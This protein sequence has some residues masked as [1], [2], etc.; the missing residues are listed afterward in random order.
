M[1]KER[2]PSVH[3]LLGGSGPFR[4]REGVRRLLGMGSRGGRTARPGSFVPPVGFRYLKNQPSVGLGVSSPPASRPSVVEF[5][6]LGSGRAESGG[7]HRARPEMRPSGRLPVE[8]VET[9]QTAS[10]TSAATPRKRAVA[11][12]AAQQGP[13]PE[14]R[15]EA[16]SGLRNVPAASPPPSDRAVRAEA[17]PP[18]AESPV[19]TTSRAAEPPLSQAVEA[20]KTGR[21]PLKH[22]SAESG[23]TLNHRPEPLEQSDQQDQPNEAQRDAVWRLLERMGAK[24]PR[25]LEVPPAKA[26]TRREAVAQTRPDRPPKAARP[27]QSDT[28]LMAA[29]RSQGSD[30]QPSRRA[31]GDHPG[32]GAWRSAPKVEEAKAAAKVERPQPRRPEGPVRQ[33]VLVHRPP[34]PARVPP[35]F[36]QRSRINL[37]R[38]WPVR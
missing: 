3:S 13:A 15:S 12:A 8:S 5:G 33:T 21:A 11:S 17:S 9:S 26:Q 38:L 30:P 16:E 27:A 24:V 4:Y 19:R 1:P 25:P 28:P 10:A 36:W 18:V 23:A 35:A 37:S 7:E 20:T 6:G 2:P 31:T 14:Q 29:E 32:A 22:L 34:R